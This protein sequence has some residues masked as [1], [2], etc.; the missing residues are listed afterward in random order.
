[1]NHPI[2]SIVPEIWLHIAEW[3][4]TKQFRKCVLVTKAWNTTFTPYLWRN[5]GLRNHSVTAPTLATVQKNALSVRSLNTANMPQNLLDIEFQHLQQ[6]T[7]GP[8]LHKSQRDFDWESIYDLLRRSA[9]TLRSVTVVIRND[10]LPSTF[11]DTLHSCPVLEM[12]VLDRCVVGL[13]AAPTFLNVCSRVKTIRLS[14][15]FLL[16][17]KTAKSDNSI[18][19]T[20]PFA[21]EIILR[22]I[23]D[24]SALKHFV[25]FVF[26]CPNLK[27]MELSCTEKYMPT[28]IPIPREIAFLPRPYLSYIYLENV[29]ISEVS[30]VTLLDSIPLMVLRELYMFTNSLGPKALISLCRH[31]QSI[32]HLHI[33][34][35]P[36]WT[37]EQFIRILTSFPRLL[38][39]KAPYIWARDVAAC[40]DPWVCTD[41][42]KFCAYVDTSHSPATK[43]ALQASLEMEH[44]ERVMYGALGRLIKLRTLDISLVFGYNVAVSNGRHPLDLQLSSGLDALAELSELRVLDCRETNQVMGAE[45]IAWMGEHW[46]NLARVRGEI[47]YTDGDI[48][49][50]LASIGVEYLGE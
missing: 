27:R 9:S 11:W 10:P 19:A 26:G 43:D 40:P 2:E 44:N 7:I 50:A 46:P 5:F 23:Q 1:M 35:C 37:S 6:L 28:T 47:V 34:Q 15:I 38:T 18:L 3:L 41:L 30:M 13:T 20:N 17:A 16:Q 48:E 29:A 36:A 12:L 24:K 39:V 42:Y 14:K 31:S 45:D 4:D 8:N 32:E 25:P 22:K 33:Q 49:E 21:S